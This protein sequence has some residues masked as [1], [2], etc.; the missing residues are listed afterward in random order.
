LSEFLDEA[1]RRQ[2]TAANERFKAQATRRAETEA[3]ERRRRFDEWRRKRARKSSRQFVKPLQVTND[4]GDSSIGL[5][6]GTVSEVGTI[7]AIVHN[8]RTGRP[9]DAD[10]PKRNEG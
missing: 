8:H 10:L 6:N 1:R 4:L 7:I 9:L 3:Q 2:E 5:H